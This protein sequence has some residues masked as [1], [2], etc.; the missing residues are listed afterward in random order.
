MIS[1]WRS[2]A[3]VVTAGVVT[4]EGM[5]EDPDVS[6]A[7]DSGDVIDADTFGQQTIWEEGPGD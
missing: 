2:R 1:V 4:Q 3:G 7:D 5:M 6:S